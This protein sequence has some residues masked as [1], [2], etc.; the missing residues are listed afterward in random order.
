MKRST[1]LTVSVLVHVGAAIG[2]GTIQAKENRKPT[3]IELADIPQKDRPKA[4][5]PP[6]PPPVAP[7]PRP[8]AAPRA[9]VPQAPLPADALKAFENLP[10]FGFSLEGSIGAAGIAVPIRPAGFVAAS[11]PVVKPIAAATELGANGTCRDPATKPKPV[12]VPR[13]EYPQAAI[14]ARVGGRVRLELKVAAT[15]QVLDVSVLEGLGHGFDEA[16]VAAA[17]RARFEPALLC[18]KA[19]PGRFTI[20]MRFSAS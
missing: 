6:P 5:Q 15:G 17:K 2:L 18:G 19:A 14:N 8:R 3:S 4:E 10:D 11:A 13:P 1:I 7:P 20:S 9:A 12:H 16:A